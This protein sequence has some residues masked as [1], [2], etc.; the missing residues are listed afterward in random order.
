MLPV[1]NGKPK[2]FWDGFQWVDTAPAASGAAPIGAV[3]GQATRKD[4]RLYVGN[5]PV[6]AGLAETQLSE[7]ISTAMKHRG[8]M[9]MEAPDPVLSV[10][11]SPEGTYAFV[12]FHTVDYANLALG[13]NT[14]MLLTS[15]LRISRPNNYQP[16]VG[17]VTATVAMP[18]FAMGQDAASLALATAAAL[19]GAAP[20][21]YPGAY[22][23]A[24]P[25]ATSL[26]LSCSNMLTP[27]E[28]ADKEER[29]GLKEDVTEECQRFG[30]IEAVKVPVY[31]NPD[32]CAYIKFTSM[33]AATAALRSLSGRKFDGRTVGV[34]SVDSYTF[35]SIIDGA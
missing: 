28:L 3:M 10:W 33:D 15:Q 30:P 2:R 12:E 5:L 35:D 32:C 22:P 9:P 27:A 8:M 25:F 21:G 17:D 24:Q 29:E 7:F 26:V 18:G 19:A 1:D 4:R 20:V 16:T 34:L 23:P 6:G 11:L 31:G 14:I 13:L